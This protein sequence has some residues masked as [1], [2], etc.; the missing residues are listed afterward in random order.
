MNSFRFV[1]KAINTEI[2]RQIEIFEDGGRVTQETRLYDSD[3]D[4]TRSMRSKEEANDY[5]YF[6][7]PDLLPVVLDEAF[8]SACR[9]ALNMMREFW[10]LI[11]ISL[12]TF[13]KLQIY[14]GKAS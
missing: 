4:E 7:D 10:F 13:P 6:P 14:Q 9:D 11:V 5:R 12:I 3:K 2:S 1:E 8:I